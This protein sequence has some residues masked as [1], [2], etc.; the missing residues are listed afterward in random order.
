MVPRERADCFPT[1]PSL[2]WV[3]WVEFPTFASTMS[4]SDH[5]YPSRMP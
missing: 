4:R 1:A 5:C 3:L 2:Q